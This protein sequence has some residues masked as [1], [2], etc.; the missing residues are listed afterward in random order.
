VS[1]FSRGSLYG[2]H[3]TLKGKAPISDTSGTEVVAFD[4]GGEL[5]LD[6]VLS[7]VMCEGEEGMEFF[8]GTGNGFSQGVIGR[9]VLQ[10]FTRAVEQSGEDQVVQEDPPKE[11]META[12]PVKVEIMEEVP[13]AKE[14]EIEQEDVKPDTT[15]KKVEKKVQLTGNTPKSSPAPKHASRQPSP[16]VVPSVLPTQDVPDLASSGTKSET[17]PV[18]EYIG[19][20][21]E[22]LQKALKR[23]S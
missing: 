1:P 21:S 14:K 4:V 9:E 16:L 23:V 3:Y 17:A 5:P 20:T 7:L 15:A 2:F 19:I 12:E 18:V 8:Y 22:E 10:L 6:S 13:K 11:N